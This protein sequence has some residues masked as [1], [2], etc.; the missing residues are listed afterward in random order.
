MQIEKDTILYVL[1]KSHEYLKSKNIPQARLDAELILA[2]TLGIERIQLYARFDWKLTEAQKDIYR[3]RIKERGLKKPVAYIIEKKHF[4]KSLFYVNPAVLIPRP[5]TEELVEWV[6]SENTVEN[7]NVLDLCTGSGCIALSLKKERLNWKVSVSDISLEALE[8]SKQNSKNLN[9]SIENFY[10]SN[11]FQSIPAQKFDLIVSNPPYIPISEKPTLEEDVRNYEPHIALFLEEPERF[12][13]N[14]LLSAK[15]Y[16]K[17]NGAIYLEI[18]P[19]YCEKIL[20]LGKKVGFPNST[21][22]KDLS[23]KWR[24]IKF[25]NQT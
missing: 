12:F 19:N 24:F 22:K 20:N 7:L 15:D 2:D 5:E 3:S 8:V 23:Q 11:L 25:S 10:Q 1:T 9:L 6:L 4:Y 16:L 13:E 14:L 18:H 21:A 17:E